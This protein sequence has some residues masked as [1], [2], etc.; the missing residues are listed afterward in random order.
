[1]ILWY[2]Q[3]SGRVAFRRVVKEKLLPSLR[4]YCPDLIIISAGFDGAHRDAGNIKNVGKSTEGMDLLP[5]DYEWLTS[6][7]VVCGCGHRCSVSLTAGHT[8]LCTVPQLQEISRYCCPGRVI[9]VL[10]GG[11]G[12][13]VKEPC[14]DAPD[15]VKFSLDVRASCVPGCFCCCAC[16]VMVVL[17]LLLLCS[18]RS[19]LAENCARHVQ[20]LAGIAQADD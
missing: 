20:A 3:L 5:S 13:W 4:A 7:V 10:E 17:L 8:S 18:Q 14:A 11:Y 6:K 2:P 12:S 1:M 15:G 19:D 9:S 16:R